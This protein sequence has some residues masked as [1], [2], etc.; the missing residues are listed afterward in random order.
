MLLDS[1]FSF[2]KTKETPLNPV[3]SGYF[4]KV[5]SILLQKE[6]KKIIPYIFE[7]DSDILEWL[8]YHIYQKSIS[9]LMNKIVTQLSNENDPTPEE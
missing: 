7:K 8:L 5:V 1:L 6:P 4:S 3:L 9:E 2:I